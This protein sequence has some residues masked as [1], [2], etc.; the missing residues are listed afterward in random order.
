MEL[1]RPMGS[2]NSALLKERRAHRRGG[3][4]AN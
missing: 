4:G 3:D 2:G 1:V